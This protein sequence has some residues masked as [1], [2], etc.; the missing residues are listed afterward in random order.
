[1]VPTPMPTQTAACPARAWQPRPEVRRRQQA[2]GLL[3]RHS[4]RVPATQAS[5]RGAM[6]AR[7]SRHAAL[8]DEPSAVHSMAS[9][10]I[11]RASGAWESS[12]WEMNSG[13]ALLAAHQV[14]AGASVFVPALVRAMLCI[15]FWWC[16]GSLCTTK[17]GG[18]NH[19]GGANQFAA[20]P[21]CRTVNYLHH[22]VLIVAFSA[23]PR[24]EPRH[25]IGS[26]QS[27]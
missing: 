24:L 26:F 11:G 25:V 14:L 16:N 22:Q 12:A 21:V 3:Q 2:L 13:Q 23:V 18:A 9:N 27:P 10:E 7:N 15:T 5:D 20:P 6:V 8:L 17:F 4:G 19:F 1:M